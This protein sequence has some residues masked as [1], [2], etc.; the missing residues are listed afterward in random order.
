MVFPLAVWVCFTR[1]T[2]LVVLVVGAG[3]DVTVVEAAVDGLIVVVVVVVGGGVEEGLRI[4]D[5]TIFGNM[6]VN[7]WEG[8]WLIAVVAAVVKELGSTQTRWRIVNHH[9]DK[10]KKQNKK[11]ID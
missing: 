10:N 2:L 4:A 6:V 5:V 9:S 8:A 7:G 3:V 11:P 1:A